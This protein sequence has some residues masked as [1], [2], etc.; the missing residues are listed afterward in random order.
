MFVQDEF[1][2]LIVTKHKLTVQRVMQCGMGGFR[3]VWRSSVGDVGIEMQEFT[4]GWRDTERD[5]GTR[6]SSE[7]GQNNYKDNKP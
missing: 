1:L 6:Y 5:E 4:G 7:H 2:Y 3:V